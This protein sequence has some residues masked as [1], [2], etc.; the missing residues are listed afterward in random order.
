MTF[1]RRGASVGLLGL[2]AVWGCDDEP[3]GK[4]VDAS[5][6]VGGNQDGGAPDG[7]GVDRGPDRTAE[8][9]DADREANAIDPEVS[10]PVTINPGSG[11]VGD[12][13]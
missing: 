9:P 5:A 8:L 4:P 2:L 7:G 12:A 11:T 6:E 13:F 3:D 10:P 1:L